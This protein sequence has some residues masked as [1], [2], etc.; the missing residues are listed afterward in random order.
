ML[1]L[2]DMGSSSDGAFRLP[3]PKLRPYVRSYVGYFLAGYPPGQH[4]GMPSPYLTVIITIGDPLH[5]GVASHPAQGASR[6]TTL[7]SGISPVPCTIV[8]NGYQHGIQLAVTPLGCRALFGMPTAELGSWMVDLD[9]VLGADA[10]ELSDRIA[11][12]DNWGER[13]AVLDSVLGRRVGDAGIDPT[14]QRAWQLLVGSG[15]H[16]RVADVAGE[17]GW[18]RRHLVSRFGAEFGVTPKDSARIARFDRAHQMLRPA[19][20][21]ALAE[22]AAACGYYD[23]AHMAREWRELAGVSPSRWRAD[24][25]F[26]FVQDSDH[27]VAA[28]ST[29]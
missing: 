13:F 3:A 19:R 4:I 1:S 20:I 15:G 18:S 23:Q 27:D 6:W 9:D 5:I 26:T 11:E 22:V 8:H 17:L 12:H 7:A 24:E 2:E 10:R 16:R 14:V 29:L 21:P 28:E 25:Q